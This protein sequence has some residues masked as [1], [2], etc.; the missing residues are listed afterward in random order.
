[1]RISKVLWGIGLG[2]ALTVGLL[3]SIAGA[4]LAT[5]PGWE[6]VP[7]T[8]GQ[9]VVS[10]GTGAAPSC[11]SGTTAVLAPTFVSS[12]VGGKPTVQLSGVNLQVI[13]G[14]GSERIRS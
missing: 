7:T 2:A 5:T 13:N 1:M 6:C 11:G 12:G 14:S 10:G 3:L 9:A 8:A 4:A